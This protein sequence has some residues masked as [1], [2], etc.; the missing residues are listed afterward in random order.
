MICKGC[1]KWLWGYRF[2]WVKGN[3]QVRKEQMKLS[4]C[5]PYL[6]TTVFHHLFQVYILLAVQHI[7]IIY[8]I[9]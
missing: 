4:A 9:G 6:K 1:V 5:R 7:Y 2:K 3:E 8:P